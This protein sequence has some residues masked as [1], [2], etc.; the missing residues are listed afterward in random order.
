MRARVGPAI[1]MQTQDLRLE[2]REIAEAL[3]AIRA[4]E[5]AQVTLTGELTIKD[6]PLLSWPR[7]LR[8]F[9]AITVSGTE[10]TSERKVKLREATLDET[11]G[12]AEFFATG[13]LLIR[14]VR[15]VK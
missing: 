8:S 11:R 3:K 1:E 2:D 13:N 7:S 12:L 6:A 10:G 15:D 5:G 9:N 4:P 14:V